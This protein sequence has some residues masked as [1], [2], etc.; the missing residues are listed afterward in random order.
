MIK[1]TEEQKQEL[2][3]L[4]NDIQEEAKLVVKD[5][6]EVPSELSGSIVQIHDE[7]PL[8]KP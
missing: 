3:K 8:L 1:L 2:Q 5:Y 4:A 7:S 6:T